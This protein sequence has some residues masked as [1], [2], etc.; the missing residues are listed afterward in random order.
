MRSYVVP[1]WLILFAF[2]RPGTAGGQVP[3]E[4]RIQGIRV[5]A[6]GTGQIDKMPP[7]FTLG[8]IVGLR[9]LKG[10]ALPTGITADSAWLL[11]G[12]DSLGVRLMADSTPWFCEEQRDCAE[13]SLA[14]HDYEAVY[15]F[16][17]GPRQ[18][19]QWPADAYRFD[20]LLRVI[21]AH[22]KSYLVRAVQCRFSESM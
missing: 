8:L 2:L 14:T 7:A 13:W 18:R 20:I 3:P 22:G 6:A 17:S 19:R 10:E 5:R 9:S 16:F 4:I 1:G 21:D 15:R 12:A 11:D